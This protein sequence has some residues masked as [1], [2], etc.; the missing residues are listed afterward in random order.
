MVATYHIYSK[1]RDQLATG[2][3]PNQKF[4]EFEM[5]C[6]K[7]P[8]KVD[9][10]MNTLYKNNSLNRVD[11]PIIAEYELEQRA[12]MHNHPTKFCF[13]TFDKSFL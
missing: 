11:F 4:Y 7:D 1:V 6:W 10:I 5:V 12:G 3:S 13:K 9:V 8:K 2:F